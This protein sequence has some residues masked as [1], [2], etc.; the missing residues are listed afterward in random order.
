MQPTYLILFPG[1]W[2]NNSIDLVLWWFQAVISYVIGHFGDNLFVKAMVY[3]HDRKNPSLN[4]YATDCLQQLNHA[5]IP[6]GVR[7]IG[8]GYSMGSQ[9]MRLTAAKWEGQFTDQ[10][11]WN[12]SNRFGTRT[13]AFLRTAF[14]TDPFALMSGLWTSKV[15]L[16]RI[17]TVYRLFFTNTK[18]SRFCNKLCHEALNNSHP[19][20][21]WAC[22]LM[23]LWPF[24]QKTPALLGK[25]HV[26]FSS[27]D[28]LYKDEADGRGAHGEDWI[29]IR[30]TGGHGNILFYE[31][32]AHALRQVDWSK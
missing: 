24:R 26:I 12:G 2:G 8:V 29:I 28:L 30:A 20:S 4:D 1:A 6:N 27:D 19:E 32:T 11:I 14:L 17:E 21:F 5:A 23:N 7:V 25:I 18:P 9:V 16:A 22:I 10:I 3:N 15:Q 31:E 13:W